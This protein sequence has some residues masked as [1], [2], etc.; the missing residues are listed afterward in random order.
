MTD[1]EPSPRA[2]S[3][4]PARGG[5]GL[6]RCTLGGGCFWCL[7]AVYQEMEGV[8]SVQSG[9]AAGHTD[10]PSYRQV[11]SGRTGHAEVV[12][13][14]YDPSVIDYAELLEVFFKTHDPTTLNRQGADVGTQYRSV[15]FY[16]DDEQ[17]R[18]AESVKSALDASGFRARSR[19]S[20][21][22][23]PRGASRSHPSPSET[24][25]AVGAKNNRRITSR[26]SSSVAEPGFESTL[27]SLT[28]TRWA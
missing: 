16:H 6:E 21:S 25:G 22:Y 17:R 18:V 4:D 26:R 9:Y 8:R 1:S 24:R 10:D 13:V 27:T 2:A 5:S 20:G 23:R 14:T 28:H 12:Q 7:E 19:S 15:V 3:D 11:C